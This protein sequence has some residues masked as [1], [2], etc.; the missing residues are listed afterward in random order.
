MEAA[1]AKSKSA[2]ADLEAQSASRGTCARKSAMTSTAKEARGLQAVK[3]KLAAA[4]LRAPEAV[5]KT[6]EQP[7]I[8][9]RG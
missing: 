9:R 7:V 6:G 2:P 1:R 5:E 4:N 3:D 8:S